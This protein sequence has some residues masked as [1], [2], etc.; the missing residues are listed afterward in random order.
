MNFNAIDRAAQA[1][2]TMVGPN[3]APLVKI[4]FKYWWL[5]VPAALATYV[6]IKQ[7]R[8][9]GELNTFHVM[10]SIGII[11]TPIIGLITLSEIILKDYTAAETVSAV[12]ST[13]KPVTDASFTLQPGASAGAGTQ[14]EQTGA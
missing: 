6:R 8:E 12:D 3:Q 7:L 4:A 11:L 13:A 9:K 5:A 14:Q 2:G 10:E 1:M